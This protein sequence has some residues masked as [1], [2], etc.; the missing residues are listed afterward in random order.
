M[1]FWKMPERPICDGHVGVPV[2]AALITEP[3]LVEVSGIV[4][5][6]SHSGVLWAHADSG[7]GARVFAIS[8]QGASLGEVRLPSVKA[9][10]FE[11]IAAGP[12]PDLGGPCIYVADTGNNSHDR[13][14]LIVYA[15]PEPNVSPEL[16]LA[17]PISVDSPWRFPF[18][19]DG[20]KADIEAFIVLPDATGMIF[21]EKKKKKAR[22]FSYP[23]PWL[24]NVPVTL[25][26][27]GE[28]DP[29][30]IDLAGGHLI[31]SADIHP[32]GKRLLLRTY[33]GVFEATI[34]P[35]G[36]KPVHTLTLDDFTL[37][38]EGPLPEPQGEAVAY[39]EAGTG[40]WT[41]SESPDRTTQPPLHHAVC[42]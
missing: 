28:I 38:L 24:A 34:D 7:D 9:V 21:F 25:V 8:T 27:M 11:D 41:V 29:P 35:Y 19:V 10:D 23:A 20:K 14:E 32:S 30:G 2:D 37:A 31:T 6:P 4:A 22:V 5:S 40:I 15:F 42:E 16:P 39:D 17:E 3:A 12:C 26:A 36:D 33:F 18:I 13:E 1:A